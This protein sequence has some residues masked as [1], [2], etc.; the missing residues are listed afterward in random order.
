MSVVAWSLGQWWHCSTVVRIPR[1]RVHWLQINATDVNIIQWH[2]G[3]AESAITTNWS[4]AS[5]MRPTTKMMEDIVAGDEREPFT[6]MT[7]SV[8]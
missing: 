3:P 7:I 8:S 2:L 5:R 1:L 4:P 6:P